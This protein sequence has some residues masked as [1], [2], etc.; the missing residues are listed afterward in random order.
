MN[1]MKTIARTFQTTIINSKIA[2]RFRLMRSVAIV[3]LLLAG[4]ATSQAALSSYTWTNTTGDAWS[5]L[6]A[7]QQD[8]YTA[9]N[10]AANT[11]FCQSSIADGY[12]TISNCLGGGTGAYPGDN[13]SA[14]FTNDTN[15]TVSFNADP[16]VVYKNITFTQHVGTVELDLSP[17]HTLS[18]SGRV[19]LAIGDATASV[20]VVGGTLSAHFA[21]SLSQIRVGDGTNGC[22]GTLTVG[23][24]A[25]VAA[26][27]GIIGASSN[28]VGSLF[29][30][31]GGLWRNV[32]ANSSSLACG[33]GS[34]GS[35][36]IMTNGGQLILG[37]TI[38]VGSNPPD[39]NNFMLMTGS[40]TAGTINNSGGFRFG[41]DGGRLLIT[42]GAKLYLNGGSFLFGS[43][44]SFNTGVVVGA[45]SRLI[46][47]A[48]SLQVGLGATGG[49]NNFLLVYDGAY[50]QCDGTLAYGNN[51]FHVGDGIQFGGTGGPATGLFNVVR[52]ASNSTNHMNNF[53]TATN[54]F[55][56]SVYMNPQ[57]PQETLSVLDKATWVLT[58]GIQLASSSNSISLTGAGGTTIINRGTVINLLTADNGGGIAIGGTA[59]SI[60]SVGTV[61]IVTNGGKLVT[62]AGTLGNGVILCTAIVSGANAVWSNF[63]GQAYNSF[64]TNYL[65]VG[66]GT[67]GS[68]NFLGVFDGGTLYNNGTLSIANNITADV[69]T[70][71]FGGPGNPA[72][73]HN[74]GSLDIGRANGSYGNS[75][76]VTNATLTA[77]IINVG[78]SGATNNL[79]QFN[80]GMISAGF[81]R[82]RPTN[83][84]VFT[85]GTLSVG[86]L[87]YDSLANWTSD[88][89]TNPF[90]VG[91]A[92]AI[93]AYYDMAAG[94]SGYH[95]FGNGGLV[96]NTNGWLRGTGTIAGNVTMNGTFSPGFSVGSVYFS[97]NV[98]F[99][100]SASLSYDLGTSSDSVTVHG[101]L[102]LG[103]TI[104]VTSN[105]GF[106]AGTYTLITHTNTVSGML[107]TNG[108]SLPAGYTYAIST[109]TLPLV[110]LIVTST[111]PPASPWANWQTYYFPGGGPS[112]A[113]TMDP[114]GDGVNNTNEF[115]SGFNPTNAAAYPHVVKIV[116]SAGNMVVTYLGANGDNSWSPGIA[117]RTNV[118]E[119]MT[120]S[121]T[122]N[123]SNNFATAYTSDNQGTNILSGGSG[124]GTNVTVTDTGG[125][126]G[127]T[128]YY[129]IRVIAP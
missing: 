73:V 45:G 90:V 51:S 18:L 55:I 129:R 41:G 113:G 17:S 117:M 89:V 27:I 34:S 29:I 66:T 30:I 5:S 95:D 67:Q 61:L 122:G 11:V 115:L 38:T 100:N 49:T 20:S 116:K 62:S 44:A 76:F 19:Y 97:N 110:Q 48:S 39:T 7:W 9:T 47:Y 120:G 127:A 98:V 72:F 65:I 37:G 43:S 83:T 118:L 96:I 92:G 15:Y 102:V 28:G 4:A 121:P 85:G 88:S 40:S 23:S 56:T 86:G 10:A 31:D 125:A 68:N 12:T 63:S 80:G 14:F 112:Q 71:R 36:L 78:N 99:G 50:V 25:T 123:Y 128:R 1:H 79:L 2:S 111:A 84:V 22:A 3:A 101:D 69:N 94:G 126:T 93:P 82:I 60:P 32:G 8:L 106:T 103:G 26:D 119:F 46:C 107:S 91:D 53:F 52:S 70:V 21:G 114:D 75:L 87:T 42:N 104:N 105:A 74:V 16:G 6:T 109:N 33:N 64:F 57:G 59:G 13:N 35:Q 124:I 77:G 108:A 54:A 81:V 58:N 24:G